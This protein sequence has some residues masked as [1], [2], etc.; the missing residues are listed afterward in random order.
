MG[1]GLLSYRF[2]VDSV[3]RAVKAAAAAVLSLIG[4]EASFDVLRTDVSTW[5]VYLGSAAGAAFVSVLTSIASHTRT[6]TASV[7]RDP[8]AVVAAQQRQ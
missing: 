8:N 5:K 2:W 6:G 4:L 7:V 1:N 3:E